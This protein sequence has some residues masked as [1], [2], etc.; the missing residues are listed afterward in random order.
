MKATEAQKRA[1]LKYQRKMLANPEYKERKNT[2]VKKI[3][4]Q[5]YQE[6]ETFRKNMLETKFLKYYYLHAQ[7][8]AIQSIRRLF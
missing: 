6:D 2:I 1:M 5:R 8:K 3:L 4:K 7:D